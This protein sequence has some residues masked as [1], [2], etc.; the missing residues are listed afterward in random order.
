[1]ETQFNLI[2][3]PW[4]PC[5]RLDGTLVMLGL[6]ETLTQAHT[7][8]ELQGENPLATAALHRLLL[9]ILHR[10]FGPKNSAAWTSLWEAG[11]WEA[12]TLRDY[13]ERWR[14]CFYLFD[15]TYPFY[16]TTDTDK[17]P[18]TLTRLSLTHAYNSTLFEH[19]STGDMFSVPAAQAA[20]W[21]VTM[22]GSGIGMGPPSFPHAA[23]PL[24]N[25]LLVMVQGK[26]LFE[27][28]AFNL[29]E[30]DGR[31]KPI[32][33]PLKQK[34]LPIW[35]YV[36]NP[37]PAH[38]KKFYRPGYLGYLTFQVRTLRLYPVQEQGQLCVRECVIAQGARW[39]NQ[40]IEDPMKVFYALKKKETG[41]IPL[42]LK[43]DRAL[44]RDAGA[45]FRLQQRE[46]DDARYRPPQA[47]E[48]LAQH[49]E[50]G[51]L[52]RAQTYN[53][54]TLGLSNSNARLDFFRHER[55][56]LPLAYFAKGNEVL[57]EQLHYALQAAEDVAMALKKAGR[58]LARWI[59][60]PA[61][62]SK[63]SSDG[64]NLIFKRLDLE[65]RYW[66][67]LEVQFQYFLRDL[68]ADVLAAT[69]SWLTHIQWVARRAFDEAA[70][71]VDDPL[72]GLK[73]ATL[74][75][76]T[77][78]YELAKV[79]PAKSEPPVTDPPGDQSGIAM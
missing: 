34:D 58:D 9:A 11:Q 60:S 71:A 66:P 40:N 56:P 49:V 52:E 53:Y 55:M 13:F 33:C 65:Q 4:L 7:L 77:L 31:E 70:G 36:T 18:E 16:Q 54:I 67:R 48:Q 46:N 24:I 57:E 79:L 20:Q 42:R 35:E 3:E 72:R 78:E 15:D 1:M 29:L 44:W 41:W 76:G 59:V 45:L 74:A 62:K 37:Y 50:D 69:A 14:E 64:I 63:A 27:T 73:A 6:Y 75:R 28:L 23:G 5:I 61:D 10:N 17:A 38:P 25:S 26:T 8:R 43:E 21:V 12:N 19:Q 47:F 2:E 32:P 39:D 22:Q 68:P 30:Y 51:D